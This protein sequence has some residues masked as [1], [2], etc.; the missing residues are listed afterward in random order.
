MGG[1]GG[2]MNIGPPESSRRS[3][4]SATSTG[5]LPPPPLVV[6]PLLLLLWWLLLLWRWWFW[7]CCCCCCRWWRL[8]LCR[9]CC[10]CTG[11]GSGNGNGS[12]SGDGCC[13]CWGGWCCCCCCCCCGD[14]GLLPGEQSDRLSGMSFSV[15]GSTCAVRRMPILAWLPDKESWVACDDPWFWCR[16]SI[17]FDLRCGSG[18][19]FI[20]SVDT[21][22]VDLPLFPAITSEI[23][24]VHNLYYII[25]WRT[26]IRVMVSSSLSIHVICT[27]VAQLGVGVWGECMHTQKIK[28]FFSYDFIVVQ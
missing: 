27:L 15:S 28:A 18:E 20:D 10:G 13:C 3:C 7:C 12:G 17:D 8:L 14:I 22:G 4:S 24:T 1:G 11:C 21:D 25:M 6:R 16:F 23:L 26:L 9:N 5:A 2:Q 19:Q